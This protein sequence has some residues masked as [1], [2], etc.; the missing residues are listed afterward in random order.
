[1]IISRDNQDIELT[2]QELFEAHEEYEYIV[3]KEILAERLSTRFGADMLSDAFIEKAVD[4]YLDDKQ[5]GCEED[6]CIEDA[7]DAV[8]ANIGA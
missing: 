2:R 5:C 1:M 7:M 6:V 4:V 3:A 8:Q